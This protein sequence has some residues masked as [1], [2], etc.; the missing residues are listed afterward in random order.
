MSATP[1]T[2]AMETAE[3]IGSQVQADVAAM[4]AEAMPGITEREAQE[5]AEELMFEFPL[6]AILFW[7]DARRVRLA[8]KGGT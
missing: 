3:A 5:R 2:R 8:V 1:R 6:S 7:L 4:V